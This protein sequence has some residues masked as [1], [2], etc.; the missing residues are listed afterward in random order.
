MIGKFL[1]FKFSIRNYYILLSIFIVGLFVYATKINSLQPIIIFLAFAITGVIGETFISF[2]WQMFFGQRFWVYNTETLYH[3]YT[4]ILNFIPWGVGGY[5]YLIIAKQINIEFQFASL[6]ILFFLLYPVLIIFQK[7]IF[8]FFKPSHHFKFHSVNLLN[9]F[10]FYLPILLIISLATVL[11]GWGILI[12]FLEFGIVAT[13][14]E[15]L[16]GK[17]C[18]SIISKKLWTYTYLP[19]D[20]GHFTPLSFIFF[21]FGGFY[22]L[23]VAQYL[24]FF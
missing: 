12:L 19:F 21:A 22:F 11:H 3:K 16:F 18:Q 23:M 10:I 13:T 4:S 5:I 17:A 2:W 14:T 7:L 6:Y 9:L 15:Y 20:Q 24:G 1:R 8:N